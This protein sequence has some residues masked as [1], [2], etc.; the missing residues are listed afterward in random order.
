MVHVGLQMERADTG[1]GPFMRASFVL[2]GSPAAAAGLHAGDIIDAI[3]G[4]PAVE[5]TSK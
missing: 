1:A 3:N 2:T 5:V 4:R